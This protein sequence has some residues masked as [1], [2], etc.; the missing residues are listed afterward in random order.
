[1]ASSSRKGPI[2]D[3]G[4]CRC[5]G[6]LKKCRLLNVEYEFLGQREIYSE[7]FVDC[8]GLVLSHLEGA[9]SERLIC[10]TCVVRLRD[11]RAFRRQVLHCEEK[12]LNANIQVHEDG[13]LKDE[14]EVKVKIE[15]H[16]PMDEPAPA[17]VDEMH[18]EMDDNGAY[19]DNDIDS[20]ER[21]ICAT[22]VVRLRDAR[23]FRRQVLHCEE[24]LLNANIQVHE[25]GELKDEPEVKVKI[26]DYTPMDEPAPADVDD[27]HAEMDDDGAHQDND[28]DSIRSE[29]PKP[30]KKSPKKKKTKTK[31]TKRKKKINGE[32]VKEKISKRQNVEEYTV[33]SDCRRIAL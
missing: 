26:E 2:V 4:L 7:M 27:M 9:E 30:V 15:E 31:T 24:K 13:E 3:P 23:A 28:A 17:D 25:D 18:A 14:P 11:A 1:M 10:A 21:L 8:F 20:S 29:S 6:A 33:V 19:Q 16:T 32:T 5:C 22:C 12:L